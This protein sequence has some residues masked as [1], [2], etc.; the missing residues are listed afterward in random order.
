MPPI[1]IASVPAAHPYVEHLGS[2]GVVRLPDP[3]PPGAPPGR[4]WPPVEV[5][6]A[7]IAAHSADFDLMHIHFGVESFT[8]EHLAATVAALRAADRPLVLTVHDLENPQLACQGA[9]VALLDVLVPAAD[10]LVT[11]TAGAA[12][13][14]AA[15]WGRRPEVIPH[16]HV[17]PLDVEAPPGHARP[18]PVV[19]LHLRDLRP[20][21]DGPGSTAMLLDAI[22]ALRG[23][24]AAVTARIELHPEVRDEAARE[25][26][27]RL[28]AGARWAQL[29][30]LPRPSDAALRCALADLDVSVLP[31]RHGTHSGWIELCWDLGVPVAAP[32]IGH[33]AEQHEDPSVASVVPGSAP[34][35]ARA[36]TALLAQPC[37]G[38]PARRAL[39]AA[40]RAARRA[41]QGRIAEAHL[42]L[43]RRA[44]AGE[45]GEPPH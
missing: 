15:R 32:R 31:Y 4:W 21:V 20:N 34:Q 7:W 19:G 43:Y 3:R 16:P 36:L 22:R 38:S 13:E 45:R 27:R 29:T 8:P 6:P 11:L 33:V 41:E 10:A 24:G 17:L 44:L 26:V 40:R 39:Q 12:A 18:D 35:L 9:H 30:E 5:D 37:P 28:C 14:V 2:L 23:A 42:A 1:R 25:E